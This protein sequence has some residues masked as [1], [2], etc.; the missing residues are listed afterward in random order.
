MRLRK[1]RSILLI[2]SLFFSFSLLSCVSVEKQFEKGLKMEQKGRFEEA[3]RY[4]IKVLKREPSWEEARERLKDAGGRSVDVLLEQAHNHQSARD[5]ERAAQVLFRVDD[6]ARSSQEV[7]VRLP[8]PQDYRDF[9]KEMMDKAVETVFRRAHQAEKAGDWSHAVSEY[10]HLRQTYTLSSDQNQRVNQVVARIYT[11]W[12]EQDYSQRHYKAAFDHAQ[13]AL[14]I[15]GPESDRGQ[16]A[17]KIQKA[18]LD[19]GTRSVAVLPFES[20]EG[21]KDEAPPEIGQELF[22]ILVYEYLSDPV[23]F[24]AVADVG[25]VHREVRRLNLKDKSRTLG[26]ISQVGRSL[27]AD[28]VVTGRIDSYSR[29][30]EILDETERRVSLVKD[31]SSYTTYVE[32][33]Y[34]LELSA[35][36][37]IHLIS[38]QRERV[39]DEE[40]ITSEVSDEF[41]RGI[42]DGDPDVLDLSLS[43]QSL[44]DEDELYRAEQEMVNRLLEE[45]AGRLTE[46]IY[47]EVLRLVG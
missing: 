27:G 47:N 46:N 3:A 18:A 22:D 19:A 25:R 26:R 24:V 37:E 29:E 7:G 43:K 11:Q 31:S 6:L 38:S 9:R 42:Y 1:K 33:R 32:Q 44:F 8:L 28:F 12:A 2:F 15:L 35:R 40:T 45:L 39:M 36:V 5:Y 16:D 10:E 13:K 17:L 20:Y 23:P 41:R 4:Y 21:E 14:E 30:E 34:R